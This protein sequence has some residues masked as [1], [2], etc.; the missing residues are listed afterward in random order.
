[1]RTVLGRRMLLP[2]IH[3]PNFKTYLVRLVPFHM[4]NLRA[5]TKINIRE[6]THPLPV[7]AKTNLGIKSIRVVVGAPAPMSLGSR[8]IKIER[9]HLREGSE[10]L[11][12][13][14]AVSCPWLAV[15]YPNLII[16]SV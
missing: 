14:P 4:R 15:E 7:P 8:L 3:S 11:L 10:S 5:T 13:S 16:T 6:P 2:A 1:M 12:S 9:I